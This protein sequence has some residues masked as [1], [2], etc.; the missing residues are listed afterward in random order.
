MLKHTQNQKVLKCFNDQRERNIPN[1]QIRQTN[2][3]ISVITAPLAKYRHSQTFAKHFKIPHLL[4]WWQKTDDVLTEKQQKP[5]SLAFKPDP[6]HHYLKTRRLY[7][8]L[9]N[10]SKQQRL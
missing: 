10:L 5:S 1:I 9:R 3:I 7:L 8:F 4:A 2:I 6:L